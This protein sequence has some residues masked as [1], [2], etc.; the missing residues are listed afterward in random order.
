[1]IEA[2]SKVEPLVEEIL[3]IGVVGGNR[4]GVFAEPFESRRAVSRSRRTAEWT[5]AS[6]P[7]NR[8]LVDRSTASCRCKAASGMSPNSSLS[9]SSTTTV[10]MS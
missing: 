2:V 9:C 3:G 6:W 5:A 10:S 4:H 8:D 1:M 7:S